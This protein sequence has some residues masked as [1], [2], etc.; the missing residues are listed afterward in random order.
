MYCHSCGICTND[1]SCLFLVIKP[2]AKVV[3]CG[4]SWEHIHLARFV[5]TSNR[6]WMYTTSLTQGLHLLDDDAQPLKT[7]YPRSSAAPDVGTL[8]HPRKIGGNV[9]S[10]TCDS[11]LPLRNL[12]L[13][14]GLFCRPSGIYVA[15]PWSSFSDFV[16]TSRRTCGSCVS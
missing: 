11:R 6:S 8:G 5:C 14:T 4:L 3:A 10:K 13:Y 12:L 9:Q 1:R 2:R 15:T 16:T 7:K